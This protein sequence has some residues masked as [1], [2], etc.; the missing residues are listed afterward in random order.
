MKSSDID[1]VASHVTPSDVSSN[2]WPRK[3]DLQYL[4]SRFAK[5]FCC[6]VRV[7]ISKKMDK[8]SYAEDLPRVPRR[9]SFVQICAR[10]RA[11]PCASSPVT[12]VLR[13]PFCET[14]R[15]TK[16]L[17]RR[18]LIYYLAG[19]YPSK[20]NFAVSIIFFVLFTAAYVHCI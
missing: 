17:T 12:H 1:R 16:R 14:M 9:L 15:E 2:S 19:R 13:S 8:R 7:P 18:L 5:L 20:L 11:V 4:S 3:K 10:L 6:K